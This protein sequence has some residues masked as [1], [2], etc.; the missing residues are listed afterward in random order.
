MKIEHHYST[1]L[2]FFYKAS[3]Q[4]FISDFIRADNIFAQEGLLRKN[5]NVF[6]SFQVL[7]LI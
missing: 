4:D 5:S 2:L 7:L 3:I 1:F 6:S